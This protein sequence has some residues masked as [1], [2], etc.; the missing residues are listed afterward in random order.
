MLGDTISVP[1]TVKSS[2]EEL[3]DVKSNLE[4]VRIEKDPVL[5]EELCTKV[6]DALSRINQAARRV[7][8]PPR[9]TED[10]LLCKEISSAFNEYGKILQTLGKGDS[11]QHNFSLAQKWTH[12]HDSSE[13]SGIKRGLRRKDVAQVPSNILYHNVTRPMVKYNLPELQ[14]RLEST[15][16]LAYC[17]SLL[18]IDISSIT[19]DTQLDE[20]QLNW[21]MSRAIDPEESERLHLLSQEILK[22]SLRDERMDPATISEVIYLAPVLNRED[23]R[24]LLNKFVSDIDHSTLLYINQLEGLAQQMQCARPGYL[25]AD[26]L[27]KILKPL[28]KHLHDIYQQSTDH[29][30]PTDHLYQLTLVVSRA[31]DAMANSDVKGLK[32]EHLHASLSDYV[33]G[34]IGNSDP[35]LVYQA[36]YAHQALQYI[37]DYDTPWRALIRRTELVADISES[38][39]A[40]KNL[41][42]SQLI[43][44]LEH[45]QD[46]VI[47]VHHNVVRFENI[48]SPTESN[49]AFLDS[50]KEAF[51][52]NQKRL[53]Y[54][55]LRSADAL[56]RNG[57]LSDF[58]K[59]VCS[60]PC[61]RDPAFEWGLCQMLAEIAINPLWRLDI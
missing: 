22:R 14:G 18:S 56:L 25:R 32:R 6:E 46:E 50:L 54:P 48:S 40:A 26:D 5:L 1:R 27:V 11:A 53:W 19:T 39:S 29:Q 20:A 57:Q 13:K 37:P 33:T 16:Q 49:Q 35:Y 15:P 21:I 44:A 36:A 59:L 52:A 47:E 43:D 23:H 38:A 28:S 12:A 4:K 55:T 10:Q 45:I 7:L 41:D 51:P 42:L 60:A 8:I 30:Q 2:K 61:R 9:S 24:K 3:N 31:L 58:K 17:L 34:L